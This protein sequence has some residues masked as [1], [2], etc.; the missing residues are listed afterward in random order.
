MSI[1]IFIKAIYCLFVLFSIVFIVCHLRLM[2]IYLNCSYDKYPSFFISCFYM[3]SSNSFPVIVWP[4]LFMASI[5]FS[6]VIFPSPS[7]SNYLN[8]KSNFSSVKIFFT[9]I[10]AAKNSV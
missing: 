3:I 8:M 6:F 10:V 1:I 7:V 4:N 5:I 2:N 9:L